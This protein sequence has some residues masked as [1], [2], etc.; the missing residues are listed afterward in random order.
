[1]HE[2]WA[3]WRRSAGG[4]LYVLVVPRAICSVAHAP[5]PVLS[6][7]SAGNGTEELRRRRGK[8]NG[9]MDFN[10]FR[11]QTPKPRVGRRGVFVDC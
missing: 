4:R 1:M 9:W 11:T 5:W 8:G 3:R 6:G 2:G 10:E 7:E